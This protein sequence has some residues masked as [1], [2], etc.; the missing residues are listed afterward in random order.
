MVAKANTERTKK[1]KTTTAA[2]ALVLALNACAGRDPNPV[3]L[4]QAQDVQASC[5]AMRAEIE[6]NTTRIDQLNS[7]ENGKAF[8]NVAAVVVGLVFWP[9]LFAMDF[10]G[11]AEIDKEALEGRNAYLGQLAT[12]RC[13]QVAQG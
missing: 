11:A 3:L 8:Q 9:A 2:V 1:V 5:P 10:K 13:A 6:A 4:T 12:E 7:E